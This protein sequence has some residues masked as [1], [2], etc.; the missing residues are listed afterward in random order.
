MAKALRMGA[1]KLSAVS[2]EPRVSNA[3]GTGIT[4]ALCVWLPLLAAAA[5]GEGRQRKGAQPR[6]QH[7]ARG[8]G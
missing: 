1:R 7:A 3:P 6:R 4:V 2:P 8:V 5:G